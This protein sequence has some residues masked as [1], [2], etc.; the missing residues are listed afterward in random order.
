MS[1]QQQK[2]LNSETQQKKL[3]CT[4]SPLLLLLLTTALLLTVVKAR[5]VTYNTSTRQPSPTPH[6]PER[7]QSNLV[8]SHH[9]TTCRIPPLIIENA[10]AT[11]TAMILFFPDN[12][13]HPTHTQT[14]P[15][16]KIF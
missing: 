16:N 14:H 1:T 10:L 15:D 2:T 6:A 9:R 7:I 13:F 12:A 11:K 5:T 3:F 8:L 4:R